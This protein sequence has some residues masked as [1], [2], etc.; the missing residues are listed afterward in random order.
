MPW[1]NTSISSVTVK[2]AQARASVRPLAFTFSQDQSSRAA[3]LSVF[4]I[5]TIGNCVGAFFAGPASERFGRRVGMM[6]GCVIILIGASVITAAQNRGMF[7]GGR[8]VLG[9]GIA[10]STTAAPTWVTELAPAHW[11]GRLGAAYNSKFSQTS[12]V[13]RFM[14]RQRDHTAHGAYV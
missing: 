7:L 4:L 9:F 6:I 14:R 2:P 3:F 13:A 11:R 12:F 10:I 5:Y 1:S 8:F